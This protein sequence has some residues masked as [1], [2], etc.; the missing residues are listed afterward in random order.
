MVDIYPSDNIVQFRNAVHAVH[1]TTLLKSVSRSDL[2][3]YANKAAFDK[4]R[5]QGEQVKNMDDELLINGFGE[6]K[7]GALVV[8]VPSREPTDRSPEPDT[9]GRLRY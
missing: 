3:V 8:L 4:K 1:A 7:Q 2:I 5:D 9:I 6:S